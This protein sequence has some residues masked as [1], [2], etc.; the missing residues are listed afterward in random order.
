MLDGINL[1]SGIYYLS[2]ITMFSLY[3][4]QISFVAM[5]LIFSIWAPQEQSGGISPL[6][7]FNFW[8]FSYTRVLRAAKYLCFSTCFL[9]SASFYSTVY[10]L[11]LKKAFSFS[12]ISS[13]S[14]FGLYLSTAFKSL[15][16]LNLWSIENLCIAAR[17]PWFL[18][19]SDL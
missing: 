18:S 4:F 13:S 7:G 12:L 5:F 8:P 19:S 17:D 6:S 2:I 3:N 9:T 14:V 10:T 15:L 16:P 11:F 1:I